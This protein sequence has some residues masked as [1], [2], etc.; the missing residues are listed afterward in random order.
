[1]PIKDAEARRAYQQK[2]HQENQVRRSKKI[3]NVRLEVRDEVNEIK[4]AQGCKD[5]KTP[6]PYYVLQFDHLDGYVKT[7]KIQNLIRSAS[8]DRV[9]EEISKCDVVC[10]N[11]HSIRTYKRSKGISIL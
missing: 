11:C 3:K 4:E 9:M 5:C 1:M 10:A 8:R 6:F 2:W 7:D